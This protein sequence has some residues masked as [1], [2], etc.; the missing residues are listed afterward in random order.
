MSSGTKMTVHDGNMTQ[1][2]NPYS[3]QV[4]VHTIVQVWTTINAIIGTCGNI[5]I[6]AA[7]SLHHK[8]RNIG[9]LFTARYFRRIVIPKVLLFEDSLIQSYVHC[10]GGSYF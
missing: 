5:M 9:K 8:L 6:I 4:V 1:Y 7:V 2:H 10:S 3:D